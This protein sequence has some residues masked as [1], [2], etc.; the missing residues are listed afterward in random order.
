VRHTAAAFLRALMPEVIA[1]QM[2]QDAE[3]PGTQ[4]VGA[5]LCRE[6][7]LFGEEPVEESLR[8]IL[9]IMCH[10]AAAA[11]VGVDGIPVAL[12]ELLHRT[13]RVVSIPALHILDQRPVRRAKIDVLGAFCAKHESLGEEHDSSFLEKHHYL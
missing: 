12:T 11:Q 4:L 5:F 2:F 9:R 7:G 10:V 8:E 3:Q 1:E 13:S 6:E